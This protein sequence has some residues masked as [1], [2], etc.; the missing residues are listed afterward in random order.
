MADISELSNLKSTEPLDLPLYTSGK[1]AKPFPK[2]GTYDARTPDKFTFGESKAGFLTVDVSPTL[3]GGEYDGLKINFTS[4]S[5]KTWKNKQGLNESQLG[6]YLKACKM[7]DQISGEPQAQADAAEATAN[8]PIKVDLDW[9]AKYYP[10]KWELRGMKNFPEDGNGGYSRAIPLDGK[11][12][13]P[14]VKD[15]ETGKP[16]IV[17]AFLEV[18]RFR[19]AS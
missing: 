5:A 12:G 1:A 2:A 18:V 11:N 17:R 9:V 14:D 16:L 4:V 7:N 13:R 8:L 3:V 10:E 19:E 6:R 15:P